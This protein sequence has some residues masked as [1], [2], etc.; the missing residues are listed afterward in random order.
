[1]NKEEMNKEEMNKEEMNKE[2][3][4]EKIDEICNIC[5]RICD[6]AHSNEYIKIHRIANTL[7][8]Y[9]EKIVDKVIEQIYKNR[10]I[11]K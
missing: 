10:K 1:M 5:G 7:E 2:E 4:N 8:S 3:M 11:K 6:G 9:G